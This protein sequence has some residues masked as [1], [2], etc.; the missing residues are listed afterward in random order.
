MGY[1]SFDA[2]IKIHQSG[3]YTCTKTKK[4]LYGSITGYVHHIDRH[5]DRRN[6]CEIPHNN[7][8][9]DPSLTLENESY[10]KN[11]SGVWQQTDTSK[12][13][14]E[15]VNRRIAYAREHG[16]RITD[17]GKND[18]VIAR[19]IVIQLDKDTIAQH[20]DTW[21]WDIMN[22]LEEMFDEKN[23]VGFSIHKDETNVHAH[24]LFVPCYTVQKD[25]GEIRCTI[26][27]TKFFRNPKQLASMH[28][29]IRKEL[30]LKGYKVEQEN[31][32]IEQHL[33]GYCDS[34]GV[35]HQQ[36]LTPQQLKELTNRKNQ[37]KE[38]EKE[39]MLEKA[40]LDALAKAMSDVQARATATHEQLENNMKIFQCQQEDFE[41]EKANL[42]TQ[43]EALITE[44]N[45][46][47]KM[48]AE[49]DGMLQKVYSVSDICQ[50][51]LENQNTLSRDFL[52]FLDRIGRKYNKQYRSTIEKLYKMFD[53]ERRTT[54]TSPWSEELDSIRRERN[55]QQTVDDIARRLNTPK[56]RD[57]PEYNFF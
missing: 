8:D 10:Y 40:E 14:T 11:S 37:L 31:K 17:K 55:R 16:A 43:M 48:K 33:A 6:G 5:T 21:V 47:K 19:P 29:H 44:K 22:I 27:Q 3:K 30:Q 1:V 42:Q 39:L 49:T 34:Q 57:I 38:K 46:I 4:T 35:Y 32:P 2:S 23:I 7:P 50:K 53:D 54:V 28:K 13:M 25:S 15:A 20:E 41:H 56:E 9:I 24:I 26:S 36:G 51:I 12:D 52:D 45:T 18:T